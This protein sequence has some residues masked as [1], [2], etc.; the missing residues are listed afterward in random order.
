MYPLKIKL[1]NKD[2]IPPKYATDGSAGLDLAA[3][4]NVTIPPR[5]TRI[6]GTGLATEFPSGCYG[7]I[8]QRSSLARDGIFVNAGVCDPDYRGELFVIL[9]NSNNVAFEVK[10]GQRIAQMV[11]IP[12]IR[13]DVRVV[14]NLTTTKRGENRLGSTGTSWSATDN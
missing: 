7:Q 9:H 8:F 11:V 12:F 13:A 10:K 3:I 6:I 14:D 2:A 5:S 1:L 4:E